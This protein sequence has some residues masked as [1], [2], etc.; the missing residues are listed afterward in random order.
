MGGVKKNAEWRAIVIANPSNRQVIIKLLDL[1]ATVSDSVK[2]PKNFMAMKS[3]L[4]VACCVAWVVSPLAAAPEKIA[5]LTTLHGRTYRECRISQVHPDGVSFFHANGAAKVLFSDLSDTWKKKF[6][7]N[8]QRAEEYQR[9]L[10]TRQFLERERREQARAEAAER[11]R[12]AF[13]ARLRFLERAALLQ[14]QRLLWQQQQLAAVSFPVA[15]GPAPAIGWPGTYYGPLNEIHGPAFGGARWARRGGRL[16]SIGSGSGGV[17]G[18]CGP[19]MV[20]T[21]PTLGSYIPGRFAA[22]GSARAFG[23]VYLG[24]ARS[25]GFTGLNYLGTPPAAPCAPVLRG[26]VALPV[27]R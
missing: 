8:P 26:S 17:L 16:A 27:A 6:G 25:L 18:W 5:E 20:W 14:E 12:Q 19:G 11:E 7:Y 9:E 13:E 21:S 24:G 10:A 2:N 15:A 23:G 4:L 3:P 22:F 1:S